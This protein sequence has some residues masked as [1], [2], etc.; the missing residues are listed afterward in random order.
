[1]NIEKNLLTLVDY[2][3]ATRL[4]DPLDTTYTI[5]RLLELFG[6]DEI[7]EELVRTWEESPRMTQEQAEACLEN[8]L[9][10]LCDYA[11]EKGI[12]T[13]NSVVYRDLFDTKIMSMLMPRPSEVIS[14]FE[15]LYANT[16]SEAATDYFYKL[17]CDSNYI[18]RYRIKKD[19][20]WTTDTAYG[21]LDITVNLSKP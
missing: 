10:E 16:S 13:E 5:N 4:I 18:R 3:L 20:K 14:N 19:L 9:G 8:L 15:N 2:A 6:L 11:Y 1:M 7:G 21:T 17:S 12:T